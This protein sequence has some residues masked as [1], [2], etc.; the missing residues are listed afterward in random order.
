[1]TAEA[2]RQLKVFLCHASGDKPPVRD[3]YRRLVA[4]GVDAWLDKEKL[5]PGQDWHAE[6]HR[7]V[8]EADV[9]VI[10]LSNKSITKE[11][12]VQRE[13]KSALD[14][15]EEKPAGTIFLIPARLE[16]CVVPAPLDR[17]QWVD[18]F[19]ENGFMRLLLSLKVRADVVGATIEPLGYESEDQETERRLDQLYTEGLAAYWVEDWDRACQR[20][21]AILRERP[22]HR[23]ASEKLQL[24]EGQRNLAKL[25]AQA[26]EAYQSENWPD[27]IK[28]LEGLLEKSTDYKDALQLLKD[29][30]KQS[31][32]V[33]LYTEAKRLHAAQKWQAVIR[34]FD[35][36]AGITPNFPDPES[37]LP[38][39]QKELAE[40]KRLEQLNDLYSRGIHKIDDGEWYEARA[41]L[42]QVHKAQTGFL[43]TERLLRKVENEIIKLEE[44]NKRNIQVNTLYGQ[45]HSLVRSKNWHKAW[46]T[47]EEIRKLD[48]QFVDKDGIFERV[49]T[50][51]DRE[52]QEA[53]RQKELNSFY[54]E[55]VSLLQAKKY[56]E[57]LEK[58]NAIQ[59]IEPKYKDTSRV[60]TTAK[61]KLDE[62]SSTE[63]VGRSWPKIRNDWF[64]SEANI[65]TDRVILTEKLLLLSFAGVA[66]IHVLWNVVGIWLKVWESPAVWIFLYLCL[67]GGL[68]GAVV[69]FVLNK[70][71][72]NWHLKHSLT[73]IIGWALSFG[74]ALTP[75][76]R[77]TLLPFGYSFFWYIPLSVV[78]VIK[79]A[80][81]STRIN[82]LVMIFAIWA[83]A[84]KAGNTLGSHLQ[85]FNA[86]YTWAIADALLIL[87]GLLFTFGMQI[88]KSR[89]VLKT[90]LFGALGFGIGNYFLE[91]ISP[92]LPPFPVEIAFTLWGLI[93]GAI[94]EAPSRDSRR[95][96]SSA[97]I[98]GMGLLVGSYVAFDVLPAIGVQYANSAF[99]VKNFTL[100]QPFLGA[101][102][103]LALGILIRRASATGTLVLL[104]AGIY[105]ITRAL[106]A[107]V[108][109]ISIALENVIRGALIG[110]VL[111]YGYGYM[112]QVKP[113][114]S[115]PP[116]TKTRWVWVGI[117]GFLAVAIPVVIWLS[118]PSPAASQRWD[119]DQSAQG[120]GSP[121]KYFDITVPKPNDGYLTFTSNGNDPQI[122]SHAG[123][124]IS[125][126]ANPIITIR[127]RIRQGHGSYGQIFFITSDDNN[128]G[129]DKVVSFLIEDD[130]IFH[131][132]NIL[133]SERSSWRGT[134]NE[135]RVDPVDDPAGANMQFAIDYISVHAP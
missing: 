35:Q 27:A 128:W 87:L 50:E 65:P 110:L 131:V 49:R 54:A 90:A 41:F 48:H 51:L 93:G 47:I 111:G 60:K 9:V 1:M 22:N 132:Y 83:F 74:V 97:A 119:F 52:E 57:A 42:E 66:I 75:V 24:A 135:I 46:D 84:W 96:L 15:A 33:E 40:L 53:Q 17:W 80:R 67:L 14:I 86:D 70:I 123:L 116:V 44:L 8:R 31:Q 29:A 106:N 13:I 88:E 71:I 21:Q 89:E 94:L 73:L 72:Y 77:W 34:I 7:A 20:F 81:P 62:L 117:I 100:S 16:D 124:R 85:I 130:G 133:M 36:I 3:L 134:I 91:I 38:S 101:G 113:L 4:E 114:E 23:N 43:D 122:A 69:A 45:V 82:S 109:Q 11:G 58:W 118:S 6:I 95:I 104:G 120:W 108:F 68:Y 115:Q 18:L 121:G 37:L 39:S 5:L 25:Y 98:G 127:M 92:L 19:E 12:Y 76:V 56:Q 55:A 112:R 99:S 32:L 125:A 103:G 10:C 28:A 61:R 59:A 126:S 129:G 78:V 107:G 105:L 64:R 63:T 30:K 79:W 26:T 2:K 102:L